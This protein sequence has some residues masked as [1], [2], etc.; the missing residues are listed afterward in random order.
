M[1]YRNTPL[2]LLYH[3]LN[4]EAPWIL[5]VLLDLAPQTASM[6]SNFGRLPLHEMLLCHGHSAEMA[7]AL[8]A[9]YELPINRGQL[10]LQRL[11]VTRDEELRGH[12]L[13][14]FQRRD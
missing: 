8:L 14:V 10:V 4:M 3:V 9:A 5:Q 7:A 2:Q 12:Q 13:D 11:I 6:S 1:P